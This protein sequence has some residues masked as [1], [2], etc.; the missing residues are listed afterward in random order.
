MLPRE[1]D[2]PVWQYR[3][4]TNLKMKASDAF[5]DG[6]LTPEEEEKY[7]DEEDKEAEL[8][9]RKFPWHCEKGVIGNMPMLN[10]EFNEFRGLNPVKIFV[11][12]PPACGKTFYSKQ[13]AE[14]YNIPHVSVKQLSDEALRISLLDEEQIGENEFYQNIKA[15]CDEARQKV[16]D[17]IEAKRD[18]QEEPA[19]GWPEIDQTKLDIRVHDDII[20]ELL[21]KELVKNACR[22]RGYILDGQPRDYY[23]A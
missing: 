22:N 19:D 23:D 14:Y 10:R 15:K 18:G 20:Y 13:L 17:E 8:A 16:A 6:T 1:L 11:T 5:K 4:Q 7:E 3:M 9:K 2:P 21:R 12:G